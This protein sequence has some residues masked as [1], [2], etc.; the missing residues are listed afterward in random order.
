MTDREAEL[1]EKADQEVQRYRDACQII[2]RDYATMKSRYHHRL[3]R[4]NAHIGRLYEALATARMERDALTARLATLAEAGIVVGE[5]GVPRWHGMTGAE[6]AGMRKDAERLERI[7]GV[8]WDICGL[9]STISHYLRGCHEQGL[10]RRLEVFCDDLRAL[11]AAA[12][13]GA[14]GETP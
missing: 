7:E 1:M 10:A 12:G 13:R 9:Q 4:R 8:A 11:A 14:E 6:I 2:Q 3:L 5:D